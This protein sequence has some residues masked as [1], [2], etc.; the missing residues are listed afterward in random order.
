MVTDSPWM[1]GS[2]S[3]LPCQMVFRR[4][5]E[6]APPHAG[7]NAVVRKEGVQ[8]PRAVRGPGVAVLLPLA[9]VLV[10]PAIPP[11][12]QAVLREF[13]RGDAFGGRR[14]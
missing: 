1:R 3:R 12:H 2:S 14:P 5:W 6:L 7:V 13:Q 10:D 4:T 11:G 8:Q 9:A